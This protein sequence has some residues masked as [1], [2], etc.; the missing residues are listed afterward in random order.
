MGPGGT[1]LKPSWTR[2]SPGRAMSESSGQV[3][4]MPGPQGPGT[5][6]FA[7][8]ISVRFGFGCLVPVKTFNKGIDPW[9]SHWDE[10]P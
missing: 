3:L 2:L 4:I 8:S 7:V 10:G 6:P 1:D 9:V 5:F